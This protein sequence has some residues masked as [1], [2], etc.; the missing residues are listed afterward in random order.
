MLAYYHPESCKDYLRTV[1]EIHVY[2][3][4]KVCRTI[5]RIL[6]LYSR[7][8]YFINKSSCKVTWQNIHADAYHVFH[9]RHT[10][11]RV[12]LEQEEGLCGGRRGGPTE[13]PRAV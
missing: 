4:K 1:F 11:I 10:K 13:P 7:K 5:D 8:K 12:V 2:V 6:T 9:W 3:R